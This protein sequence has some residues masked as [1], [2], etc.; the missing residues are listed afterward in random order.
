VSDSST[1]PVWSAL[2]ASSGT[3]G[4]LSGSP[5]PS[6]SPYW[7]YRRRSGFGAHQL[8]RPSSRMVAGT[9]RIRTIV[10][11]TISATIMP[12]PI[13]LMNVMPEAENAPMTMTSSSAALVITPPVRCRP[14]ATAAVLSPVT[15]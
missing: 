7:A 8:N 9:S 1:G 10:A 13:S 2:R 11:S 14:L 6:R 5:S 3:A 4:R 15:S 12:T